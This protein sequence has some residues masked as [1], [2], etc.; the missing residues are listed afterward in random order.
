MLR[1]ATLAVSLL[2][3]PC[4]AFVPQHA[5]PSAQQQRERR[6]LPR[7]ASVAMAAER[8]GGY[9]GPRK[10]TEEEMQLVFKEDRTEQ[11]ERLLK[12]E[13]AATFPPRT[14]TNHNGGLGDS[15]MFFQG[16]TPKTAK[17]DGLTDFFKQ[18]FGS[19][20]GKSELVAKASIGVGLLLSLTL[21]VSLVVL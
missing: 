5:G 21:L 16:P 19:L 17:Q 12:L 15:Y 9:Q 3:A 11:E 6:P 7:H 4:A 18:D 2:L 10:P 14:G 1:S 13:L 8:T 20:V